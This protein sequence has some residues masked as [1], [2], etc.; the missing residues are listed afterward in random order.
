MEMAQ[1]SVLAPSTNRPVADRL[2]GT[3]KGLEKAGS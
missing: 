3:G 1:D 2:L